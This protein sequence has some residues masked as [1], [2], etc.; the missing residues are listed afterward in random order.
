M[1]TVRTKAAFE[2][3]AHQVISRRP[4]ETIRMPDEDY[5]EVKDLCTLLD[6]PSGQPAG[7]PP[8]A[9]VAG[10]GIDVNETIH[11]VDHGPG[12]KKK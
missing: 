7:A 8:G 5:E 9:L 6:E 1:K 11:T 2:T 4:G 3:K 12:K 10:L